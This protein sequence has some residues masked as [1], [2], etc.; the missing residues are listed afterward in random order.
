MQRQCKNSNKEQCLWTVIALSFYDKDNKIE[1][2]G[3]I[4]ILQRDTLD[5][6]GEFLTY[7]G[8]NRLATISKNVTLSD[9]KMILSTESLL[10]NLIDKKGNYSS[11]GH[12][13]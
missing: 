4:R 8:D 11:G 5:L 6:R 12:I 7:D 1:A 9:G 10:Y 2:F 13:D 3:S